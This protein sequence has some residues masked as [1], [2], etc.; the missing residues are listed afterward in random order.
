MTPLVSFV[1]SSLSFLT[2]ISHIGIIIFLIAWFSHQKW[3]K[4]IIS[5]IGANGLWI[6]FVVALAGTLLSLFYSEI[7]RY[8]PCELCW[9]QRVF[10]Y[11][12][13]VL[14]A[15]ALWM[16]DARVWA[17]SVALSVIG[18]LFA[19]YQ[20]YIQMVGESPFPCP[21]NGGDCLKRF[22]FE[23]GFVTFPF[24][25]FSAFLLLILLMLFV[26]RRAHA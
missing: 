26:R 6:G 2:L 3:A 13:A 19:L 8:L 18:A 1:S 23:Y 16:K 14:F 4:N 22:L 9:I 15:L 17:Y 12:Q 5:I 20:H 24:V 7:A 10:L 11:P 21:A 25:A